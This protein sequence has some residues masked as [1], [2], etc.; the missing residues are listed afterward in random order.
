MHNSTLP[1]ASHA[2]LWQRIQDRSAKIGIIGLGYVGLP[3]ALT[4]HDAGY[5][6]TGF[7]LDPQKIERLRRGE[8]YIR[9]I[10]L[11]AVGAASR[12]PRFHATGDMDR[13]SAMDAILICVP[14]PL[15][16]KRQPDLHYVENTARD[17]ARRLR[18][19]QLIILESTTY[20]GT[21]EEVVVPIL[22]SSGMICRES[23]APR[24]LA[25]VVAGQ[26]V[27]VGQGQ[28]AA[29][30]AARAYIAYS[31]EREDPGNKQFTTRIIPK[32]VGGL[33][34]PSSAL[35]TALYGAAFQQVIPVSSARVAEMTKILEN[36]YRCVN[37][38]LMNELNQLCRRM[39]IDIYEVIDAASTKPFGFHPF[40]PGPGMG[41]HCIPIDPFYLSWKAR[42]YDFT[43]RFIE[44]AG[45]INVEMPYKVAEL[46]AHSLNRQ[47]RA[48]HGA[49]LL[50][51]GVA[52]KRDIDDLR[53]SPALKVMELLMKNGAMVHYHDPHCP[54][55]E[56][57]RHY[58]FHM[59]SRSFSPPQAAEYDGIVIMTDHSMLDYAAIASHARLLVDTRNATR[60]LSGSHIVRL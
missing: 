3:L 46:V 44:L 21:T 8:S 60:G 23:A 41:G 32:V 38:A 6:V 50:I 47:G 58:N 48:L 54:R 17:I 33:D 37:I 22:E 52:Y 49:R 5:D 43:T 55:I 29:D 51:L 34:A 59:E 18:P 4:F 14:T 42:D 24:T 9:H 31:P 25:A 40:Y 15:D 19:G 35:A 7:D 13:L 56:P 28:V 30:Q 57:S 20:P 27:P 26:S 39:D 11:E 16:A 1:S 2:A 12:S 10:G 45:E 36:T 53:E